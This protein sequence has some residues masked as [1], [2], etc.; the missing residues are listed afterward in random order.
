MS[1]FNL[2]ARWKIIKGPVSNT[3]IS[4]LQH[5]K[6]N[7]PLDGSKADGTFTEST[8][9]NNALDTFSLDAF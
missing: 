3:H 1:A 6:I 5:Q 9:L 8:A 2:F 4:P 7:Y